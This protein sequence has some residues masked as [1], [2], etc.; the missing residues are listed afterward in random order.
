MVIGGW[1]G[2]GIKI[3]TGIK[4][5][6]EK[7]REAVIDIRVRIETEIKI[8]IETGLEE[9]SIH[10][11]LR[12]VDQIG[13]M[14]MVLE[15]VHLLTLMNIHRSI[16]MIDSHKM[17]VEVVDRHQAEQEDGHSIEFQKMVGMIEDFLKKVVG[18]GVVLAAHQLGVRDGAEVVVEEDRVGV[19][20]VV[21]LLL[22]MVDSLVPE[23]DE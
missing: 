23:G 20:E 11:I 2:I 1:I 5:K 18:G 6:R 21:H 4:K 22:N 17:V 15:E 14:D 3:D 13:I 12:E 7:R 8:E 10:N 9:G 19:Q 16:F